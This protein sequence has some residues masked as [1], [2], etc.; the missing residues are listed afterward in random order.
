ML[1]VAFN[2]NLLNEEI[3]VMNSR[4]KIL[5]VGN[6]KGGVGKTTTTFELAL[7]FKKIDTNI[8]ILVLDLD[9]QSSLSELLTRTNRNTKNNDL[10]K[11]DSKKTLNYVYDLNIKK[12]KYFK[13]LIITFDDIIS[14]YENLENIF[15]DFIPSSI[16]YK[17]QRGDELGLDDLI[18]EMEDNVEYLSI[19]PLFLKQFKNQYDYIFIDSPPTNNL[20][21]KSMFL[22]SD[23]FLIPTVCDGLSRYGVKHYLKKIYDSYKKI[24][25][26]SENADLA[27]NIF[28][29]APK[30]IGIFFNLIRGRVDYS[31]EEMNM[32]RTIEEELNQEI[33]IFDTKINNYIDYARDIQRGETTKFRK[34]FDLLANEIYG[35]LKNEVSN[36]EIKK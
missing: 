35:I 14:K 28:G 9:P 18:L 30:C 17:N 24:C 5:F 7:Q 25:V 11:F 12:I 32:K 27:Y 26:E 15:F 22:T 36:Y 23:Y 33:K 16:F 6:Y 13:S 10:S 8:K 2:I 20:I 21:T 3:D 31:S 29:N 34:D 4:G 1:I 19:L